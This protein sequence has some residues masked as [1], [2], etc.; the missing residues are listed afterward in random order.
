MFFWLWIGQPYASGIYDST[1]ILAMENGLDLLTDPA[2]L[3]RSISPDGQAHFWGEPLWGYYNSADEWVIR[4]QIEMLTMA[5]V[6]FIVFDTTNA[7]TYK[8]VY[9]KILK[10]IDEYQ[11]E[12]FDPPK[13]AFYTHS[14]SMDTVRTLYRELYSANLYPNTWYMMNG[15]PMIIG[16]TDTALDKLEAQSRG[17]SSYS[18]APYS[19]E[20]LDFFYFKKPQWPSDMSF[21]DGFPWIEWT[22]PQPLHDDMLSV[23]VASHPQVPFSFSLTRGAVNWGRGWDP[24]KRLNISANVDKGTFFQLQWDT[25][26]RLDPELVFVG[27]W[28]EW[29]AYKQMY[30]GEYMLCDAVDKEFSRDIEP[31]NG[32]YQDAFYLQLISNVRRF[33]GVDNGDIS[34]AAKT[35]DHKDAISQ[36]DSVKA[37]YRNVGQTGYARNEFAVTT[38]Y[39]YIQAA[40]RNNIQSVKVSHDDNNVYFMIKCQNNITEYTSGENWMN[41]FI[42]TGD[43]ALKAWENYDYVIGRSPSPGSG[44]SSIHKLKSDFSGQLLGQAEYTVHGDSIVYKIPRNQLGLSA[45]NKAFYF[46]VTDGIEKPSDIMDTYV[47]GKALPMGRLSYKYVMQ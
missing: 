29:I 16:Y 19:Q 28:N 7:L 13:A 43:P 1:K 5:D 14:R 27:G 32:G 4:K 33:K 2:S 44:T 21:P 41:V 30:L 23:T 6:D 36:W 31:M 42:G 9:I 26:H 17:D 47:T 18:P 10:V 45:I 35:I 39:K 24:T 22:Y 8:N 15:K 40:P 12:G 38:K 34:F 11:R 3:N 37:V 20:I 25:A 46:K